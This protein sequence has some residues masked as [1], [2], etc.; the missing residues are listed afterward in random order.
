VTVHRKHLNNDETLGLVIVVLDD[1]VVLQVLAAGPY[2]DDVVLLRLDYVTKV[3][4]CSDGAYLARAVAGLGE[5]LAEFEC[6]SDVTVGGLLRLI[7]SRVELVCVYGETRQDY[8]LCL[9]SIHRIGRKRL[10]L[11]FIGRD[12]V[13]VDF[14]DALKLKDIT[15]I[16]FGGRY[17]RALERF[18]DAAPVVVRRVKR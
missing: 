8:W 15:R 16:E 4:P 11:H 9:G 13:W 5:P 2:L 6:A 14:V 12:G 17:I 10:D 18:G 1:W 3:R 7:E